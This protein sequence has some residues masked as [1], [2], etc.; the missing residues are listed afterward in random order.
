MAKVVFFV[1]FVIITWFTLPRFRPDQFLSIG[2]K[3]LFPLALIN[4]LITL[5]EIRYVVPILAGG[6]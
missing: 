5:L 6:A 1:M 3:V 4:L 2:W